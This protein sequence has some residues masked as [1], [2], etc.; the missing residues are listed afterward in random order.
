MLKR[1]AEHFGNAIISG[2]FKVRS[3][4]GSH[5]PEVEQAHILDDSGGIGARLSVGNER[6]GSFVQVLAKALIVSKNKGFVLA[7]WTASSSAKLISLERRSGGASV[8]VIAL[9]EIVVAQEFIN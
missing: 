4:R 7:D 2:D 5:R 6:H 1:T 8:E 3:A 9:I